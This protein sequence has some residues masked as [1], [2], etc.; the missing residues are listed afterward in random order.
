MNKCTIKRPELVGEH[1]LFVHRKDR[2]FTL[3]KIGHRP[4]HPSPTLLEERA[5]HQTSRSNGFPKLIAN[6]KD[7]VETSQRNRTLDGQGGLIFQDSARRRGKTSDN[8]AK[9]SALNRHKLSE[10]AKES[11]NSNTY[12][13]HLDDDLYQLQNDVFIRPSEENRELLQGDATQTPRSTRKLPAHDVSS[14]LDQPSTS[15]MPLARSV[16][17]LNVVDENGKLT[18]V[19]VPGKVVALEMHATNPGK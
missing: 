7:D 2:D 5:V 9:E 16:L 10:N 8:V 11:G 1:F 3:G 14:P 19:V 6:H 4:G 18:E 13:L 17:Q 15:G 12:G